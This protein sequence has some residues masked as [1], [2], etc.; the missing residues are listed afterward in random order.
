M[1]EPSS[2]TTREI[3]MQ[4]H[5]HTAI[6]SA[7]HPLKVWEQFVHDIYSIF[8]CTHLENFFHHINNLHQNIK[9]TAEEESNG[10]LAFLD[11]WVA[12]EDENNIVYEIDCSNCNAVYFVEFK[13]FLNLLIFRKIKEHA[14]FE[15]S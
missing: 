5:E 6:S 2:S 11:T 12:T 4:A 1:G 14:L 8:E 13:H 7:L 10:E 3:Y 15:E 9:F